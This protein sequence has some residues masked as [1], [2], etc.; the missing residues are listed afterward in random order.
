MGHLQFSHQFISTGKFDV[1]PKCHSCAK[2]RDAPDHGQNTTMLQE[3][4]NAVHQSDLDKSSEG[5]E[6]FTEQIFKGH[7]LSVQTDT[8]MKHILV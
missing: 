6:T 7:L 5:F 8:R 2:D 1:S 3:N 4:P